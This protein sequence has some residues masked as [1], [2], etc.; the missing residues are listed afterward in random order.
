IQKWTIAEL[1]S[2]LP[3]DLGSTLEEAGDNSTHLDEDQPTIESIDLGSI[4]KETVIIESNTSATFQ[5]VT[6][7]ERCSLDK[8][9]N[10]FDQSLQTI[11]SDNEESSQI[12]GEASHAMKLTGLSEH[13]KTRATSHL[14]TVS[15]H[16]SHDPR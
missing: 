8:T 15:P 2:G 3:D 4:Q 1:K 7:L 10:L 6:Q 5:P 14:E 16:S 12:E 9:T 11:P 13:S